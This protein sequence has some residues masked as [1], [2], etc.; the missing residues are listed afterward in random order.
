MI[1]LF[2]LDNTLVDRAAAFH[3]WASDLVAS[4][5]GTP[6][7]LAALL[8]ADGGG[9]APKDHV[10]H[11]V[12]DRFGVDD[13]VDALVAT[14]RAGIRDRIAP[15]DGVLEQLD[16][17]R[18]AG[19]RVGVVTNGTSHQQRGKL[20]LTGLAD[21]VDVVVVSGEARVEKPDPR[22]FDL[23]LEAL[24]VAP[25]E[26]GDVWMVGDAEGPDVEGGRRAGLRTVWLAHGR[27]WTGEA[28]PD[29]VAEGPVEAVAAVRALVAATATA[30]R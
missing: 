1:W 22:I 23:A 7:D 18:A 27:R 21:R 6:D 16:A 3:G 15:Y 19:D 11:A 9:H 20:A 14:M 8:T 12:Q 13:D 24:G 5:G 28:E 17:L 29:V 25:E 26:R 2:D 10:A 30:S 4:H